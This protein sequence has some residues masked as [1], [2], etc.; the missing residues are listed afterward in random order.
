[1]WYSNLND[2]NSNLDNCYTDLKDLTA[3]QYPSIAN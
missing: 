3:V 1:M 2:T